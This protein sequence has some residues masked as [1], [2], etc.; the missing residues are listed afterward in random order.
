MLTRRVSWTRSWRSVALCVD[1]HE[2]KV[3][4][5]HSIQVMTPA[6]P[7]SIVLAGSAVIA[8]RKGGSGR[9]VEVRLTGE[10]WK[11][12]VWGSHNA[13]A[14]RRQ[15][16]TPWLARYWGNGS[17][18]IPVRILAGVAV[19]SCRCAAAGLL[20]GAMSSSR[21]GMFRIEK[22]CKGGG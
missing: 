18:G 10:I 15:V 22:K 9:S 12:V 16:R 1:H 11:R 5:H 19:P 6:N 2:R 13:D 21:W 3:G 14:S 7:Q 8:A 17:V 4:V 20:R